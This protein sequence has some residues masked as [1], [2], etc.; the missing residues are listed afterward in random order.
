[1]P[2]SSIPLD[3]RSVLCNGSSRGTRLHIWLCLA[4]SLVVA[5]ELI[6]VIPSVARG[7]TP[8]G[9]VDGGDGWYTPDQAAHGHVTFNSFCAEC[10]RPDLRGAMGPALVGDAFLQT[11]ANRP[12]GDLF[13]FVHTRMPANNPGSVPEEKLWIITA[14]ILQKNGFPSGNTPLGAQAEGRVLIP[15]PGSQVASHTAAPS[16]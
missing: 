7:S 11:W 14:Y 10:H 16:K 6:A 12:L 1:M 15:P 2:R 9:A 13:T 8:A 3:N 5:V 4:A